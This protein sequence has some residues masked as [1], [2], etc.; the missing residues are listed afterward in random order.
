MRIAARDG[1][2]ITDRSNVEQA[3]RAGDEDPDCEERPQL[4]QLHVTSIE[5]ADN[6][7]SD[8]DAKSD[9]GDHKGTR[10]NVWHPTQTEPDQDRQ[11]PEKSTCKQRETDRIHGIKLPRVAAATP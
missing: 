2:C 11:Q 5:P 3:R 6:R 7:D 4:T 9:E 10:R 1:T 8:R